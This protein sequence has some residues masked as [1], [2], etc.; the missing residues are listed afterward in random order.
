MPISLFASDFQAVLDAATA[1]Q[2]HFPLQ[3][4]GVMSGSTSSW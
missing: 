2:K 1:A 4:I 3:Q